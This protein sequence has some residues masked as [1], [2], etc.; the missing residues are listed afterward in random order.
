ML[1]D[2]VSN[3]GHKQYQCRKF[4]GTLLELTTPL[5]LSDMSRHKDNKPKEPKCGV[6][7]PKCRDKGRTSVLIYLLWIRSAELSGNIVMRT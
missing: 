3:P 4:Y 2:R 5:Y 7:N 6:L 1:P